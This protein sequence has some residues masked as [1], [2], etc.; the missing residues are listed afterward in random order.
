MLV[1]DQIKELIDAKEEQLKELREKANKSEDVKELRG[2]TE[3]VDKVIKELNKLKEMYANADKPADQQPGQEG[4]SEGA[5]GFDPIAAM[6]MRNGKKQKEVE[7]RAKKFAETNHETIS[8]KEVRAAILVSGGSIA[9]PVGVD[10]INDTWATVS[11]IVDLVKVVDASNMGGGYKIAYEI[12]D[13]NAASKTEGNTAA[14]ESEPT[15]GVLTVNATDK[16]LVSYISNKVRK[17][18]PLTYED[19]VRT[20]AMNALRKEASKAIIDALKSSTIAQTFDVGVTGSASKTGVL[21]EKFLRKLTLTYGGDETV[22]GGAVLILNKKDL[23]ALGD[24]R[25]T[26]EKKAVFEIT[27]NPQNPNTG[28]IKDGGLAVRYVINNNC[29]ALSGTTQTASAI[30]GIYYGNPQAIELALFS[31][32]EVKTSEDYKF[33]EDLLAVRGTVSLGAGMGVY[34]G[35]VVAQIPANA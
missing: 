10:G 26:N 28:I 16:A 23:I 34:H 25:G 15:F 14:T 31:D 8:N 29:S 33:A 13:S 3:D 35:F 19:K 5:R 21:D 18:S 7:E 20:S 22:A 9:Q 2:L 32:Y 4:G 30:K 12:T 27:P 6:E 1:K 24:I 11:S 17:Q